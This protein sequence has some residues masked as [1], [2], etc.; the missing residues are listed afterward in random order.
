MRLRNGIIPTPERSCIPHQ[1]DLVLLLQTF[2]HDINMARF[3]VGPPSSCPPGGQ[4]GIREPG[5]Q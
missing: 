3:I 2:S 1:G 4:S 5:R